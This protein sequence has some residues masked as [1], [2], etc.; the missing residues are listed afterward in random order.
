MVGCF[1]NMRMDLG[2]RKTMT[3]GAVLSLLREL[4]IVPVG[5]VIIES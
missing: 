2:K 4:N 1:L 5:K 3:F